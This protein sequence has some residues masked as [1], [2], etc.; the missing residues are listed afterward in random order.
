MSDL[1]WLPVERCKHLRSKQYYM[2]ASAHPSG[3]NSGAPIACW[4]LKTMK[5]FGPDY[6]RASDDHCTSSRRC[7]E[8]ESAS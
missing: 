2:A 6:Q 4:C 3:S 8:P 5:A 7:F 1:N